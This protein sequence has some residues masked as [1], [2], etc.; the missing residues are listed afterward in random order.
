MVLKKD[1]VMVLKTD[2]VLVLKQDNVSLVKKDNVSVLKRDIVLVLKKHNVLG[3]GD[4]VPGYQED[5]RDQGTRGQG[6]QG[7]R[8]EQKLVLYRHLKTL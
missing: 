6:Y 5:I 7:T 2:N 4:R 8:V 3:P 1:N